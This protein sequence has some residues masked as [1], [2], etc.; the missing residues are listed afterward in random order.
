MEVKHVYLGDQTIDIVGFCKI[1]LVY[2]YQV[3]L[4]IS[5][6]KK[7]LDRFLYLTIHLFILTLVK[8]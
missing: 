5:I 8:I 2:H 6:K 4:H 7:I 1:L 3:P